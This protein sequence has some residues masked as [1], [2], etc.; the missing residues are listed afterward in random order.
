M[1]I[2]SYP[3]PSR[4][5]T[6]H[7]IF[8]PAHS[9]LSMSTVSMHR[10]TFRPFTSNPCHSPPIPANTFLFLLFLLP[11]AFYPFATL[12]LPAH[13]RL[14]LLPLLIPSHQNLSLPSASYLCL[15]SLPIAYYTCPPLSIAPH[16]FLSL[17]TFVS[18]PQLTI[19]AHRFLSFLPTALS[20]PD[21]GF[22]SLF[23]A[24]YPCL[25]LSIRP[26]NRK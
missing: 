4:T 12:S 1:P 8:M 2:A 18:C 7:R 13:C 5:I 14:S 9:F 6:P 19:P 16:R 17:S 11:T 20:I 15:L 10:S 26:C 25:S 3:C 24:C 23:T 22:L 21:Y